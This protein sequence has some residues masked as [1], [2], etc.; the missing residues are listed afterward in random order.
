MLYFIYALHGFL[1]VAIMRQVG[2]SALQVLY[3]VA[4]GIAYAAKRDIAHRDIIPNNFGHL[5]GRGYLY[6]FSAAKV[7]GTATLMFVAQD[8]TCKA[9]SA[10]QDQALAFAVTYCVCATTSN[11][12][13]MILFAGFT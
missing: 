7:S 2:C 3:H 9:V 10:R 1:L 6:D 13:T 4:C 5:E 8:V 11:M 12:N